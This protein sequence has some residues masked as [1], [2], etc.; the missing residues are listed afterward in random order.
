MNKKMKIAAWVSAAVLWT[1][2]GALLRGAIDARRVRLVEEEN[3][4]LLTWIENR[5]DAGW[6]ERVSDWAKHK[7]ESRLNGRD[8]RD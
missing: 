2:I 3:K 5:H 8:G 4:L 6:A 1:I 7:A